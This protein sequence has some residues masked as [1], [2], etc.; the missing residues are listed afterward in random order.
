MSSFLGRCFQIATWGESHGGAVGA[1]VEGCPAGV[2]LDLAAIQHQQDRRRPGQSDLVTQRKETDRFEVLS[3]LR[4]GVTLGTP[5]S[6]LV[7]NRDARPEA[8]EEIEEAYRPSHADFTWQEKHGIRAAR[9]HGMNSCNMNS[10]CE[11]SR[12]EF[13]QPDLM[14]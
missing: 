9:S 4:D 13:L 14:A 1:V 12:H 2:R 8:Y 5:I 10:Y 3:G 6:L 11:V 7:P